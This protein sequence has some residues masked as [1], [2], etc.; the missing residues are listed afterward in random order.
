M[1]VDA[2]TE[3]RSFDVFWPDRDREDRH[4]PLDLR[5]LPFQLAHRVEDNFQSE[6]AGLEKIRASDDGM[7]REGRAPGFIRRT[8]RDP[9][10]E[11][12]SAAA[13]GMD[14]VQVDRLVV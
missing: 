4:L 1:A 12:F 8:S 9:R 13:D 10:E 5:R 2:L 6:T 14:H 3:G 11:D 7:V